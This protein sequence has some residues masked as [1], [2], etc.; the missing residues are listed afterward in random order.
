MAAAMAV[1]AAAAM[2]M[3]LLTHRAGNVASS[4]G[5]SMRGAT[6][7]RRAPATVRASQDFFS[8]SLCQPDR[9]CLA[10]A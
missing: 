2:V 10:V 7:S 6:E 9:L 8:G 5:D 4:R 1:N 3:A